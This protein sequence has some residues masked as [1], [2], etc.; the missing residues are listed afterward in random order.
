MG[1]WISIKGNQKESTH[2][3]GLLTLRPDLMAYRILSL[4]QANIHF[5]WSIRY[6]QTSNNQFRISLATYCECCD[7]PPF[8]Q[9]KVEFTAKC[10]S[11]IFHGKWGKIKEVKTFQFICSKKEKFHLIWSSNLNWISFFAYK[12]NML[13]GSEFVFHVCNPA[14]S[15]QHP[16]LC[17]FLSCLLCMLYILSIRFIFNLQVT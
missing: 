2:T 8:H 15:P 16:H 4:A 14:R 5:I 9:P 7:I 10:F 12:L 17:L 13:V 6:F 3:I 11:F 1:K